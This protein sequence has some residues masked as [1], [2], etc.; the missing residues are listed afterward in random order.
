MLIWKGVPGQEGRSARN[1]RWH[2]VIGFAKAM[3]NAL[4]LSLILFQ[5][6]AA[7]LQSN[8]GTISG[9]LKTTT[10]R[11]AV[12]VRVTA[13][14]VPQSPL[15]AVTS[16]SMVSLS[17]TDIEGRFRL[18]NIPP[19]RYYITAGSVDSPTYFPGTMEAARGT[20]VSVAAE[21]L[22]PVSILYSRIPVFA[23]QAHSRCGRRYRFR[24]WCKSKGRPSDRVCRR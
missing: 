22:F 12:G 4:F 11:P 18:E 20:I 21:L 13:M 3:M 24:L 9:V 17:E 15:D 16:F 5:Q 2:A 10:G 19:G 14:A 23:Q 1:I 7:G 6:G 8:A